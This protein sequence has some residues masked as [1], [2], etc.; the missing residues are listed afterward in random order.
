MLWETTDSEGD[1][2]WGVFWQSEDALRALE[3]KAGTGKGKVISG[4]GKPLNPRSNKG[5]GGRTARF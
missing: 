4:K 1:L 5:A 3:I 2:E